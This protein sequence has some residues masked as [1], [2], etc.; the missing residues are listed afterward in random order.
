MMGS[1]KQNNTAQRH[2]NQF[3]NEFFPLIQRLDKEEL[4]HFF[5]CTEW[6][7]KKYCAGYELD[8]PIYLVLD[9]S[10]IQDFKHCQRKKKRWLNALSYLVFCRF[11]SIFSDRI[12]YLCITPVSV[13][14]HGGKS[15]PAKAEN[16]KALVAEIF[17]FLAPCRLPF[18][19]VGF[20]ESRDLIQILEDVHHDAKFMAIFAEQIDDMDLQYDLRTPFGGTY[21]PLSI[22]ADLIPDDMPLRYFNPWYVKYIFTSRIENK[23]AEQSSQHPEAQPIRS[24][25]RSIT[26]AELNELKRGVLKGIGDIDL[27]QMCDIQRQ[28]VTRPGHVLLGQTLDK[29]LATVLNYHHNYVEEKGVIGGSKDIDR[30][31]KAAVNLMFSNPFAEQ[32]ERFKQIA[33]YADSFMCEIHDM[34]RSVYQSYA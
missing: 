29:T 11:I 30:Q 33:P 23:I 4:G 15:V 17:S 34:C 28:Y 25:E 10:I 2:L 6:F 27:L 14:E 18:A 26:L 21:I 9:N 8:G 16:A 22:A 3:K 24:G 12:T 32:D 19:T 7:I 20:D 5:C 13:Y 31:I 1:E